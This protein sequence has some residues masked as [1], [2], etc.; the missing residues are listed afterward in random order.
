MVSLLCHGDVGDA[1]HRVCKIS[2]DG[3]H[4]VHTYG[5]ERGSEIGQFN[6]PSRLALDNNEFVL[7]ADRDN[8]RVAVLSPTL[9]YIRQIVSSDNLKWG[10]DRLQLDIQNQRLYVAET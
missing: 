6:V 5:D 8:S 7:V 1:V 3:C 2:A 9:K 10:S 4:I